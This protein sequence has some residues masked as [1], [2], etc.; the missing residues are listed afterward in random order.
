MSEI[1]AFEAQARYSPCESWLTVHVTRRWSTA[2]RALTNVDSAFRRDPLGRAP[3]ATRVVA[4]S[5][6]TS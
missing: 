3:I 6:P 4:V 5:R 1:L 2:E